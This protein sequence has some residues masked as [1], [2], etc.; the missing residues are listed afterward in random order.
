MNVPSVWLKSALKTSTGRRRRLVGGRAEEGGP[1]RMQ[2]CELD[3]HAVFF[4][5]RSVFFFFLSEADGS[6]GVNTEAWSCT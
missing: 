3:K 6:A 2:R 5:M 4:R 1:V